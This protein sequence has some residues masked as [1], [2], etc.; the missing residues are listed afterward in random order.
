MFICV[1]EG[2]AEYI[3]FLYL[4]RHSVRKQE[5]SQL[6]HMHSHAGA[7]ERGRLK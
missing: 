1:Y 5:S 2:V 6:T 3:V 4:P 7:W